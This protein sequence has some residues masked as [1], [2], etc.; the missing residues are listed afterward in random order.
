[1]TQHVY[2][3]LMLDDPLVQLMTIEDIIGWFE[4]VEAES[5]SGRYND[6]K[7]AKNAFRA[8]LTNRVNLKDEPAFAA[9]FTPHDF[10]KMVEGTFGHIPD[11]LLFAVFKR[12][13]VLIAG[14]H[15]LYL[16]LPSEDPDAAV[17]KITTF[18]VTKN[19]IKN[20]FTTTGSVLDK[21]QNG[22]FEKY[23]VIV[24]GSLRSARMS[25]VVSLIV[26]S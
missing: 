10:K 23:P 9:E 2:E 22:V 20:E 5:G 3:V 26:Y 6:A 25:I 8:F 24:N 1:M 17:E 18:N 16:R 7:Y 11:E 12:C 19:W 21:F 4:L 15:G 14:K 13:I